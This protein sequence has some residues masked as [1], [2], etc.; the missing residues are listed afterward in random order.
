MN[1]R[2]RYHA[3]SKTHL[4]PAVIVFTIYHLPVNRA[5][6]KLTHANKSVWQGSD[7][8]VSTR[9]QFL[10]QS[11]SKIVKE[12]Q[13]EILSIRSLP[14]SSVPPLT[15]PPVLRLVLT[16]YNGIGRATFVAEAISGERA[17]DAGEDGTVT[18]A[19]KA[20]RFAVATTFSTWK[21]TAAEHGGGGWCSGD[22][23]ARPTARRGAETDACAPGAQATRG[24]LSATGSTR[25]VA[26]AAGA[27]GRGI[28]RRRV[29]SN[30]IVGGCARDS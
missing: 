10:S 16:G 25:A 23:R 5:T 28:F 30:P 22:A 29:D 13:S 20:R 1:S 2:A 8:T 7:S 11:K 24:A 14:P 21:D 26:T 15:A 6:A 18:V 19:P 17:V 27:V 4:H 9:A 3:Q 12:S